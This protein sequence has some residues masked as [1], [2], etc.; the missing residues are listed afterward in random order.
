MALLVAG[1]LG[2]AG[3]LLTLLA[4][5]LCRHSQNTQ[6]VVSEELTKVAAG[7]V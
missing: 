3:L 5:N 1:W 4:C 7:G 6:E 2:L